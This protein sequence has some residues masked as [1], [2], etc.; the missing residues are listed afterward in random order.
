RCQAG[1][2]YSRFQFL[3]YSTPQNCEEPEAQA[4]ALTNEVRII[5]IAQ[6][7]FQ[8]SVPLLLNPQYR[9]ERE[10]QAMALTNEDRTMVIDRSMSRSLRRRKTSRVE[11]RPMRRSR[12]DMERLEVRG[13][14]ST[15]AGPIRN[16]ATGHDYY[17]L[18]E[19]SWTDAEA[20]AVAL[21]G[22]LVTINNAE[23]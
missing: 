1:N 2:A 4:M 8:V 5:V 14:M 17:L 10:A 20:Q 16:P 22:H 12:P 21:G 11:P 3:C 9:E 23:E 19:S 6:C 15:L 7:L 13:L 18:T